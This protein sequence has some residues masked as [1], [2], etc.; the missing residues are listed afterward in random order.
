MVTP[1]VKLLAVLI[2][3]VPLPD[4]VRP[5]LPARFPGPEKVM[6]AVLLTETETG[7]T[8]PLIE[9]FGF[10]A[11]EASNA[12]GF[13]FVKVVSRAP[14]QKVAELPASQRFVEPFPRQTSKETDEAEVGIVPAMNSSLFVWPSPSGSAPAA[15]AGAFG[16]PNHWICHCVNGVTASPT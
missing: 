8:A 4:L 2:E 10:A 1:P 12:T 7:D 6:L 14:F 5:Q 16:S 15:A 9:T 11:P 13:P 3:S